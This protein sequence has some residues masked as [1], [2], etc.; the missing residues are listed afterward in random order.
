MNRKTRPTTAILGFSA[1]VGALA[2]VAAA[3]NGPKNAADKRDRQ[4]TANLQAGYVVS[5]P[6]P[7][8]DWSQQ[9]QTLIEIERMQIATTPT[10][11]YFFAPGRANA[12]PISSCPSIGDPIPST[13]QL[14]NPER[15][16]GDTG[17]NGGGVTLPQMEATGVFTGAS[18]AT[19]VL[20]ATAGGKRYKV[21]WEGQVFSS[22]LE[23]VWDGEKLVPKPGAEPSFEFSKGR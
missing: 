19:N 12:A 2:F 15:P 23:H 9:R 5:Q 6:I 14:T 21:Y 18:D 22:T 16:E 11:S 10:W 13:Y 1:A 4:V 3:C 20:C 17:D 8:G 7:T